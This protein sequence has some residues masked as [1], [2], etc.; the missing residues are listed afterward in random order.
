MTALLADGTE[1]SVR[2]SSVTIDCNPYGDGSYNTI[3]WNAVTG[4]GLYRVY[5]DQGGIWAY[6]GQTDTT[7]IIDENI[8]PDASITPPHYDDAFFSSKGITSVTVNNGG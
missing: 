4:A 1:E 6:V 2:S 5:R 7:K 3:K 8:T